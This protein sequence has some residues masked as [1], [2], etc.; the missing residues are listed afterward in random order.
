MGLTPEKQKELL[1][2]V[3]PEPPLG[4]KKQDAQPKTDTEEMVAKTIEAFEKM[5]EKP[6]KI[7]DCKGVEYELPKLL[8]DDEFN[9]IQKAKDLIGNLENRTWE[10]ILDDI[11]AKETAREEILDIAAIIIGKDKSHIRLNFSLGLDYSEGGLLGLL[12]VFLAP[13]VL[14]KSI[15]SMVPTLLASML[16]NQPNASK[17]ISKN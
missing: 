14:G 16:G 8:F 10:T 1:N 15:K 7:K 3:P 13:I 12:M 11:L 6:K 5:M 4:F 9:L 17:N 2:K